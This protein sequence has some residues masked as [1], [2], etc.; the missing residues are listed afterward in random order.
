IDDH[1]IADTEEARL[2]F[3]RPLQV[4][5][6]PLMDGMNVVG[7]LFG[8][9]KMFLPQVVKSAR[10]MKRAVAHL[11]PFIEKGQSGGARS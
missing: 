6:G 10:V 7:D 11:V 2:T 3:E 5:E 8:S 1:I 4:I 9:G